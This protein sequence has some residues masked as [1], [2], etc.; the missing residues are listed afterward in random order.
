MTSS[1]Y[2]AILAQ[3]LNLKSHQVEGALRLF[4]ENCTVPFIARYR[5]EATGALD[6]VQL[7]AIQERHEYL[8]DLDDRRATVLETIELQ[9]KLTEELKQKINSCTTKAE[10]EDL[11]LPYKPRRRTRAT[12]AIELGLE[13]LA[14]LLLAQPLEGDPVSQAQTYVN[15]EGG[16]PDVEAALAGARDIVA[17]RLSEDATI[18]SAVRQIL[19]EQGEIQSSVVATKKGERSPYEDY[20]EYHELLKTI[21]SH[22]YLAIC[23]GEEED[24][25]KIQVTGPIEIIQERCRGL[26]DIQPQSAFAPE[27]QKAL[28]DAVE[29]LLLPSISNELRAELKERSDQVA[30]QVFADNVRKILLASPLGSKR[31]LAVDPGLRTGCKITVLDATGRCEKTEVFQLLRDAEEEGPRLAKIIREAKTEAIAIGN[32]TGSREALALVKRSLQGGELTDI[33]AVTVNESG[34][35]VYSASDLARA[36]LPD[37][38]VTFRGAVS[39]GRRLQDPLAELVKIDPKSIGVGQYQH[40]VHQPTLKRKLEEVVESCVNYVGVHLNTASPELLRYVSGIGPTLAQKIV[41]HR[42][43]A[44]PFQSREELLKVKSFGPKAYEQAA[45]FLRVNGDN[46]LDATAVHPERYSLVQ[47]MAINLG[48][49]VKDLVGN[50]TRAKSIDLNKYITEEVGRPT[51]EDII[52]QLC[53]PGRDPRADFEAPAFRDDVTTLADLKEGMMLEGVVTNVTDFGAFVDIGVHQDGLVHISQLA[54]RF[55]KSAREVTEV[56]QKIKVRVLSVDLER[57]RISLSAKS[58]APNMEKSSG[59]PNAEQSHQHHS[60]PKPANSH[61]P[62]RPDKRRDEKNRNHH[63]EDNAPRSANKPKANSPLTYNPF[64]KLK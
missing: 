13:P 37:L 30:I 5:K 35:S 15:P 55:I 41:T 60:S 18:R 39:I 63:R 17:E 10:L 6:E 27:L 58:G 33:I 62:R 16:V 46:P 14:L 22:R 29:R 50:D 9:G 26:I 32:G 44:G 24:F 47:S 19:S 57:H 8:Q 42:D 21:P 64:S 4:A 59:S 12:K 53:R 7:R 40:D 43:Q 61:H 28:Q 56:G 23:R 54:D 51:L 25:L 2:T 36:E 11:Y 38:D 3:E 52:E 34:A 31:V 45:G 49:T 20:Y 1:K 48:I